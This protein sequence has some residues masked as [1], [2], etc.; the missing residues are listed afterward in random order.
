MARPT[1]ADYLAVL[2]RSAHPPFGERQ[3]WLLQASVILIASIHLIVDIRFSNVMAFPDGVPVALLILP[4]GYAALRY[5]LSGSAATAL[6]ASVL[7]LPDL[8]LPHDMGHSGSD[9]VGLLL[10][11]GVGFFVGQRVE[12]ERLASERVESAAIRLASAQARYRQLFYANSSPIL[13]FDQFG[14]VIDAN[15]ASREAFG[16]DVVGLCDRELFNRDIVKNNA[17]DDVIS[18]NDGRE[19]RVNLVR[20]T[21]GDDGT[22]AQVVLEDV[23]RERSEERRMRHYAELVVHAEEEQRLKLSREL[24]DEPLQV[25]MHLARRLAMLAEGQDLPFGLGEILMELRRNVL[26]AAV[27]LRAIAS[28]L[29]PPALDELGLMPALS[30]LFT[31]LEDQVGLAISLRVTGTVVRLLPEIELVAFRIVQESARNVVNHAC[32][33]TLEVL[34]E[35]D[36]NFV[37]LEISDDGQGFESDQFDKDSGMHLG[38]VG[39]RER[40]RSLGGNLEI[41]SIVNGGTV[42]SATIPIY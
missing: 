20:L 4:V 21:N 10:V 25:L 31:D 23:T 30:S 27:G 18:I 15:L 14:S 22:E 13:V 19:Y 2:R 11:D 9:L 34:V 42:V 1:R 37:R 39:M 36:S 12:A 41:R 35:F 8:L 5:G 24:H 26:D 28:G 40:A 16:T 7:W 33:K 32:A 6:W 17:D 29:R 3:F 38:I